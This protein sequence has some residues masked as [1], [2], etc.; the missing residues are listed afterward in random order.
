MLYCTFCGAEIPEG[1]SFCGNCGQI[2]V[3]APDGQTR[4]SGVRRVELQQVPGNSSLPGNSPAMSPHW[5]YDQSAGYNDPSTIPIV[6]DAEER[7]RR[8]AM[9]GMGLLA[10]ADMLSGSGVPTVQGTPQIGAVPTVAN[11]PM[12]Q[13]GVA[14]EPIPPGWHSSPTNYIPQAP[15]YTPSL[16]TGSLPTQTLHHP[17]Y[18][19]P[20][21]VKP[22]PKSGCAPL[23]IIAILIPLALIGSIITL[24]FTVFAPGLS[25]SGS[26]SVASG[27]TLALH[28]NHFLPGSSITLT[29]D[30]TTPI[31][32]AARPA[33]R[34][35][36][37]STASTLSMTAA[38]ILQP[39]ASNAINADGNGA[40]NVNIPVDPGWSSGQHTIQASEAIT[41]RSA[42][43]TFTIVSGG[44]TPTP[45]STTTVT[46]SPTL[47]PTASPSPTGT[48]A[49]SCVNPSSI[50]LGPVSANYA[51]A[52][53]NT[54]TLCTT[55]TGSVNWTATWDQGQAPW[56]VF[57]HSAGTITAPG[58]A[59]ITV[60][61]NATHMTAGNYSALVT[62]SSQSSSVTESL[63]VN[64]TVQADCIT[65]S[66][67]TLTFKALLH[68]SEAPAQKVSLS[69]CGAIGNWSAS[70]KTNDGASWLSATPTS[71][72]LNGNTSLTVTINASTLN[73]TLVAGVYSG[74]VTFAIGSNT[75]VVN[76]TFNVQDGP[77]LSVSVARLIGNN[78]PCQFLPTASFYIC[79]VTLTNASNALSLNWT[80]STNLLPGAAIKPAS[81]TLGPG[82]SQPRVL[83]EIPANE[84]SK[85]ASITF[86]G[87]ANSVTL[88]WTCQLIT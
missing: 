79:Y 45:T 54:I 22:A 23:L 56:L 59:T 9:M 32:V 33:G 42:Q 86:S 47:S 28:G 38:Q 7:R 67:N 80:S 65:G 87:P 43:L 31:F 24:S 1:A 81:G 30:D 48:G 75:F 68:V 70:V 49:L 26:N 39:A 13:G 3:P 66:P 62:F 73:S 78:P 71:G 19:H 63:T 18:P 55:G 16:P 20:T 41:H 8:A 29:L 36:A 57:D 34:Q 11:P 52:V 27:G 51:Q 74:T 35:I 25:L 12:L 14:G 10:G 40:F 53:S 83:I 2:P 37:R 4:I 72:T 88:P 6:D 21:P 85:G 69:N 64:F 58:Q 5:E 82:Q 17:P 76:V 60:F 84:C 46:P 15:G 50:T 77:T 61:A 44:A